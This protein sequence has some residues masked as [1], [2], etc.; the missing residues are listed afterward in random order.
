MGLHPVDEYERYHYHCLAV[1]LVHN[2][3][4]S[5]PLVPLIIISILW[6]ICFETLSIIERARLNQNKSTADITMYQL[7]PGTFFNFETLRILGIA[8]AGAAELGECLDAIAKIKDND[9]ESWHL[10]WEEQ[11]QKA[12]RL[13]EDAKASGNRLFA[14]NAYF[15]ASNYSRASYYMMTGLGPLEADPRLLP[16]CRRATDQFYKAIRMFDERSVV[17]LHIPYE[18]GQLR[19]YLYL[20]PSYQ[21]LKDRKTPIVIVN[22]GADGLSEEMYF[23]SCATAVNL[24]Y[25]AVTYE[26]PG[27]GLQLHEK[28]RRFRSDWEVVSSAVIDHVESVS[29]QNPD[30]GLDLNSIAI[31]GTSLGGQFALRAAAKDSR[32]KACVA[33]DPVHDFWDFATTQMPSVV[34]NGWQKGWI[35]DGVIDFV[36][37]ILMRLQFQMK[38]NIT[39]AGNMFGLKKPS[40]ITKAMKA[41]TLKLPHGGN[42]L[43]S[44]HCPVLVSGAASSLYLD[45]AAH[46]DAVYNGLVNLKHEQDKQLW[47]GHTAGDGGLQGKVAAL[48]LSNQRG[49]C[50][51]DEK[52]KIRR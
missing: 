27:Q 8:P 43:E 6:A 35:S 11:A 34:L 52:L 38:W 44:I 15:R 13:A 33:I 2:I 36:M 45:V 30:F 28:A 37:G 48:A 42:L 25:A 4:V 18:D 41:Y 46:T 14:R 32:I 29:E 21:R 47:V 5:V 1:Y 16:I 17:P 22:S 31:W 19:G 7:F 9:P 20:P 12:E 39:L 49:F 24:G 10:A 3:V 51:L 50:F 40:A 23:F 26:G